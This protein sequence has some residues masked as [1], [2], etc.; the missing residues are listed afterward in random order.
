MIF[1]PIRTD[2]RLERP[3]WVNYILIAANVAVFLLLHQRTQMQMVQ[4]YLLLPTAPRLH[5][6]LSYQFLHEG[7]MHL[8]GN[9][10]FLFLFGN[11]VEDRIGKVAYLAF[12]LAGGVVAGLGHALTS[13]APVL[14]ASG[15]VSAVA[16]AYLVLFPLSNVTVV[17]WFGLIGAFEVSSMVLII[18]HICYDMLSA[19]S[20]AG[21]V[22]YSA[23]LA[24]YTFG[25]VVAMVLLYTRILPREPYDML[26]LGER[27]RR[28][29]QFRALARRGFEPWE[30][31]AAPGDA[32][33][34]ESPRQQEVMAMRARIVAALTEGK[35]DHAAELYCQLLELDAGQV[36]SRA[37][38][39]DIANRLTESGNYE[40]GARAYELYLH[41]FRGDAQRD[42]VELILGLI[43]VRHLTRRQRAR[44]LLTAAL[45]RLTDPA[46]KRLAEQLLKEITG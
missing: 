42:Q 40:Y 2:R 30:H 39:L 26:A 37:H 15:S 13:T 44:E 17:Y 6:F 27:Y 3:P 9:M 7:W 46:Q 8:L 36:M 25:I 12:Y 45:P 38:Q 18:F 32:A 41:T 10:L 23:H 14:G 19:L 5:Q 34:D 31:Q 33:P 29:R 35:L 22:A 1:L 4:D 20:G 43:Y 11:S 24:G 28:R 21:N 16:G